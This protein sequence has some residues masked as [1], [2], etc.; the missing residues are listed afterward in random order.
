MRSGSALEVRECGREHSE[1][2]LI[3]QPE[4]RFVNVGVL[5]QGRTG[6][7]KCYVCGL[8]QRVTV[9]PGRDRRKRDAAAAVR[10]GELNRASVA[11]R[12][13]LSLALPAAAPNGPHSVNDVFGLSK[14]PG[15]RDL[16]VTSCAA[17][18]QAAL[19]EDLRPSRAMNGTINASPARETRVGGINNHLGQRVPRNVT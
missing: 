2:A 10:S 8:P 17:A 5:L 19:L 4:T 15:A 6:C 3:E 14:L 9:N 7:A 13:Q 16:C 11:R 12:E 18:M 1:G